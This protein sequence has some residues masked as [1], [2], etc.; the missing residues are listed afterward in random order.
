MPLKGA[1]DRLIHSLKRLRGL[2]PLTGRSIV[3][4]ISLVY[5]FLG[6]IRLHTDIVSASVAFGLLALMLVSV[7]YVAIFSTLAQRHL[8]I[9]IFPPDDVATSGETVRIVI[10]T[11]PLRVWPLALLDLNLEFEHPSAPSTGVRISGFRLAERHV[12]VDAVFPHRGIWVIRSIRCEVKDPTGFARQMWRRALG[13]AVTVFPPR[14]V[15]NSLP[16]LSSSQR[17]GELV[18]DNFNRQGDPFDIK[19]YHPSDGVKRIIWKTFAKR[20]ELLSRH[21][22]ASMTPEGYVVIFTLAGPRDDHIC[23]KVLSYVERLTEL[24]LDVVVGCE[25]AHGREF[26]RDVESTEKLLI[27]S[28]WETYSS[29]VEA[30]KREITALLDHCEQTARSAAVQKLL[31]FA[32]GERLLHLDWVTQQLGTWLNERGISPIFCLT[33]PSGFNVTPSNRTKAR[34]ARLLVVSDQTT[35]DGIFADAYTTFLTTCAQR[36]WEVYV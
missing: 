12:V 35:P 14:S 10:R 28:V 15:D 26:G 34:V 24:K 33:P 2:G 16:I 9:S 7:L 4:L 19:P 11:S 30:I 29:S 22:E 6:P 5:L 18:V 8:E 3:L 36:H 25:G 13:A 31:V 32:S 17:P 23:S 27:D 21:P 1:L 20:G